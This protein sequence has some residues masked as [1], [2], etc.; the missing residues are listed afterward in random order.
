MMRMFEDRKINKTLWR[1]LREQKS[2]GGEDSQTDDDKK[3][4]RTTGTE[5]GYVLALASVAYMCNLFHQHTFHFH[6]LSTR[7]LRRKK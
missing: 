2:H 6:I 4:V 5:H 1:L 3:R 7:K